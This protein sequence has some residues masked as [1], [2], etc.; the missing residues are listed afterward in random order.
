M[1]KNDFGEWFYQNIFKPTLEDLSL[2]NE[3]KRDKKGFSENNPYS[4]TAEEYDIEVEKELT[5]RRC[6]SKE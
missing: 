1:K 5:T 6:P 3:T 4:G 2:P